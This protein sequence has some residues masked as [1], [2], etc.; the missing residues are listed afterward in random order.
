MN[1]AGA[2]TD[3]T[4]DDE[5]VR[6]DVPATTEQLRLVRLVVV[7]LATSHG[8]DVDDLEDLRIA[9]GEICA[10][11]VAHA[12]HDARLVVV[13]SIAG[14]EPSLVRLRASIEGVDAP[15]AIDVLD[16]LSEMVLATTTRSFGVVA[17]ED[18]AVAWFDRAVH[19][20]SEPL[21]GLRPDA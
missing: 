21:G 7:G 1:D 9:T 18:S 4:A 2:S 11:L 15:G 10:H 16:E 5:Y 13:A 8:A 14:G 3:L 12:P 17:S 19:V 6:L 20:P